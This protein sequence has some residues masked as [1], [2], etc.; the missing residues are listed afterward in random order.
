MKTWLIDTLR[1]AAW[2]PLLV[3]VLYIVVAKALNWY[4][5]FPNLDMPTHFV[6]GL[7]MTYFYLTAIR[8][9]QNMIGTIPNIVQLL[10]AASLTAFTAIIWEF[11]EKLSDSVLHT[12]MNLGV[13][14]TLSDLFFGL[15]GAVALSFASFVFDKHHSQ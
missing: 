4:I 1:R 6:G 8:S 11:L 10:F 9:S 2:A 7:A 3:F 14:D 13:D 5:Q 15:L 12:K